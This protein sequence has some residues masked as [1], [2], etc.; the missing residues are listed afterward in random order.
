MSKVGTT[1][2]AAVHMHLSRVWVVVEAREA[3]AGGWFSS[4]KV[5]RFLEAA[6]QTD[7]NF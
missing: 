5:V 7:G 2:W 1:G 3:V 4:P 6:F